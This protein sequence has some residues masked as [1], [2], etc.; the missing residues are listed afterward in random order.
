[1]LE[2]VA[3][4]QEHIANAER[5]RQAEPNNVL[6]DDSTNVIP[7]GTN[8]RDPVAAERQA[9]LSAFKEK[10]RKQEIRIT[11][12]MVAQAANPGKWNDRTMVTRWK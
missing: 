7:K 6:S 5:L 10:G 4:Q 2:S 1:L 12:E 3:L 8:A 9:T 11:D